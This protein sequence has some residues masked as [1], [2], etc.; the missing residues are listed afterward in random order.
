MG[1][2]SECQSWISIT[3]VL[4]IYAQVTHRG[5]HL[6]VRDD[7]KKSGGSLDSPRRDVCVCL[8]AQLGLTL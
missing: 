5:E 4:S 3:I 7:Q 1:S 8:C 6:K 2:W